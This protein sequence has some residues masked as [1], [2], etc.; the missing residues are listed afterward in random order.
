MQSR[1]KKN[2]SDDIPVATQEEIAAAQ[3]LLKIILEYHCDPT[4]EGLYK[5][6]CKY[7]F[8]EF[9]QAQ[10]NILLQNEFICKLTSKAS[11]EMKLLITTEFLLKET[12]ITS[13]IEKTPLT[14]AEKEFL[15]YLEKAY[16][17]SES[18]KAGL[19]KKIR[20]KAIDYFFLAL[21]RTNAKITD[22][23]PIYF[24]KYAAIQVVFEFEAERLDLTKE[25][26]DKF[27][28]EINQSLDRKINFIMSF[29]LAKNTILDDR[30]RQEEIHAQQEQEKMQFE[31]IKKDLL[32]L[33]SDEKKRINTHKRFF[34]SES[35]TKQK[36]RALQAHERKINETNNLQDLKQ[37][38][39]AILQDNQ[40][41]QCRNVLNP[42]SAFGSKTKHSLEK[43]IAKKI[44][45]RK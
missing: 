9:T 23:T 28:K 44:V 27:Q 4:N 16:P 29:D 38:T 43:F 35:K 40:V 39:K 8:A 15:S 42:F 20:E 45:M 10:K 6:A 17:I 5:K 26:K 41:T 31:A 33:L 18:E 36:C 34:F 32:E 19:T 24:I 25:E 1:D 11:S 7:C 30:S 2:I 21:N 3:D 37:K 22:Y 13:L 14:E 12:A